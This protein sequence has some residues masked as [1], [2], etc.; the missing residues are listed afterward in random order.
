MSRIRPMRLS[1]RETL[2]IE[3]LSASWSAGVRQQREMAGEG[4]VPSRQ[5]RTSLGFG[6]LGSW[7]PP[8]GR[9]HS[10]TFRLAMPDGR[11]V[12]V[13]ANGEPL[14][15]GTWILYVPRE[16]KREGAPK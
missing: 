9:R 2:R 8:D 10:D 1:R 12:Y 15:D 16:E 5:A 14:T 3:A 11:T 13:D 4:P 7:A 6:L